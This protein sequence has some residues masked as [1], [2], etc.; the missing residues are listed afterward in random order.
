MACVNLPLDVD[1]GK[2]LQP[3]LREDGMASK[4]R[5][6]STRSLR[7]PQ[8]AEIYC[9]VSQLVAW[10]VGWLHSCTACKCGSRYCAQRNVP[11]VRQAV[12]HISVT[13]CKHSSTVYPQHDEDSRNLITQLI[14]CLSSSFHTDIYTE[15]KLLET[16]HS[17]QHQ[18]R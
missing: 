18:D 3:D 14:F 4:H 7:L 16:K 9:L 17:R 12:T 8:T 11:N 13:V 2:T 10:P 6:Q 5:H 1:R 15:L